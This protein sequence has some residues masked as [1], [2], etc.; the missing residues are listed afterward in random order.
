MCVVSKTYETNENGIFF[1][2]ET[3]GY[4]RLNY[5]EIVYIESLGDFSKLFTPNGVHNTL[6][7]L[8]NLEH[9]L[10][11]YYF[12]V[13]KQY[14]VNFNKIVSANLQ[15]IILENDFKVPL[16]ASYRDQI[17]SFITDKTLIRNS[18]K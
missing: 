2:K 6:I 1:I 17:I 15:E 5:D 12:R 14:I 4:T 13:H 10:P 18:K 9:Q 8:K 16:S 11:N 7:N 3:K